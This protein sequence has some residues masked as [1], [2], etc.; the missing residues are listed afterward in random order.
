MT[1][2]YTKNK[3]IN[4]DPLTFTGH[5][6]VKTSLWDPCYSVFDQKPPNNSGSLRQRTFVRWVV[7]GGGPMH[8]TLK[9]QLQ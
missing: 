7:G 8:I 6:L 2:I 5:T 3:V 1:G 4:R 9:I